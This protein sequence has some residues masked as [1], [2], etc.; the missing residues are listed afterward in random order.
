MRA[1]VLFAIICLG[2]C[3]AARIAA[4]GRPPHEPPC[5]IKV[6]VDGQF[7]H[8]MTREQWRRSIDP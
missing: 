1:C 2:G 4:D 7:H 5:H 3:V 8:C 6:Y